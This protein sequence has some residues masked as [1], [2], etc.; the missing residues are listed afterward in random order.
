MASYYGNKDLERNPRSGARVD[1]SAMTAAH[2]SLPFGTKVRVTKQATAAAVVTIND[3]GPEFVRGDV[4]DVLPGPLRV[5]GMKGTG[6]APRELRGRALGAPV[7][8][9]FMLID[10]FGRDVELFG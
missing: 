5:I 6:V 4:I 7:E 3:R 8:R 10:A 9:G 1:P 2:P